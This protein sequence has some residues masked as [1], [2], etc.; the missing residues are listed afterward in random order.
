MRKSEKLIEQLIAAGSENGF[1]AGDIAARAGISPA[2]LSRIRKSGRFNADTLERLLSAVD[3]EIS[4]TQRAKPQD[5]TLSAIVTKLNAS[6]R[7]HVSVGEMRNLLT[8]FRPSASAER[9]FSH[10]V[11]IVEEL[12]L[13]QVHDLI[14]QGTATLP[15]LR[16]IAAY[17]DG[18]GPTVRWINEQ[19]TPA[20]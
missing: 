13:E 12:P 1:K 14:L 20:N 15:A 8:N 10:L 18:Q 9:A 11:G 2:S 17:V 4:V 16:R 6:R 19:L 3:C 7:E 5:Q